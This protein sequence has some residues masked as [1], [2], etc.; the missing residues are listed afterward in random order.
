MPVARKRPMPISLQLAKKVEKKTPSPKEKE[1]LPFNEDGTRSEADTGFPVGRN[2]K[3]LVV[4]DNAVVLKAFEL[5]LTNSGFTVITM[6]DGATVASTA[7]L[8]KPDLII[9]DIN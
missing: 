5:K 7:E 3:I 9:L 8:E 1:K 2:R 6:A 4:D